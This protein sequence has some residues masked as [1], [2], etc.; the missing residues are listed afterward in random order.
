[1]DFRVHKKTH[2][3]IHAHKT[4]MW[5]SKDWWIPSEPNM[6]HLDGYEEP[7]SCSATICRR[8]SCRCCSRSCSASW[9]W[10][11]APCHTETCNEISDH[12][13]LTMIKHNQTHLYTYKILQEQSAQWTTSINGHHCLS[14]P[15]TRTSK[16]TNASRTR[17]TASLFIEAWTNP[18]RGK[19]C[20]TNK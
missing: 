19:I 8:F 17:L 9:S 15:R 20:E 14:I 3:G 2:G 11:D 10:T 13:S 1:M 16:R 7:T 5:S 12:H 4:T 18:S 6:D